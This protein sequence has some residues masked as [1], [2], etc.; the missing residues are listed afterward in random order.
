MRKIL[1]ILFLAIV[2]IA[3]LACK[4]AKENE[5]TDAKEFEGIITYHEIVKS[6]D[7]LFNADDTVQLFYAHGN[8]VSIHS[9]KSLKYHVV[10]DYYLQNNAL[11]L[12]LFNTSDTLYKLDLNFS[13]QKLESFK[14]QKLSNQILSRNCENI[15]VNISYPEKDSTTYTDIDFTF[16]RGYLK[17]YKEHFKN[18]ELGYFNKVA[19]EFG[20]FYLKFKTV[21]FDSTHKNIIS[22]KS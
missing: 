15:K 14:V 13:S 6:S 3:Q 16:S 4:F 19:D 17:I 10:K 22:S 11:R 5:K 20:T 12:F 9:D 7:G 1:F 21:H 2:S 8:F 18:W